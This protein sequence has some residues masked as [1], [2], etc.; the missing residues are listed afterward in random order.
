MGDENPG[1]G[2]PVGVGAGGTVDPHHEEQA[3][4]RED[5]T[6]AYVETVDDGIKMGYD[7]ESYSY[8]QAIKYTI[9]VYFS[10]PWALL[11]VA[12]LVYKIYG[13]IKRAYI[14]PLLD[15][16]SD[17]RDLK[18]WEAE[19]AE[20]KKNPDQYRSKM[21]ELEKA[22]ARLQQNYEQTTHEWSQKQIELDEKRR[23]QEIE[24]WE[25]HQQGKG[26]KNRS[27]GKEDKEREALVQQAKVNKEK[28]K[29][30]GG[31]R[32]EYN[33]L[34]GYGGGSG[35]RAARRNVSRGG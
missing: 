12:F 35:F 31:L 13:V 1:S 2:G 8:F 7:D 14:Y 33:P 11:I 20:I 25:D 4:P 28:K 26:Y 24:D 29:G 16:I 5:T 17:W 10:N 23:Q 34:M 19:A 3:Q 27:T 30:G 21:E 9:M 15:R 6:E 32:P 22:R 18:K